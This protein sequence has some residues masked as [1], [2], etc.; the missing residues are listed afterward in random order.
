MPGLQGSEQLPCRALVDPSLPVYH[1]SFGETRDVTS[2]QCA[3]ARSI[4]GRLGQDRVQIPRASRGVCD[5]K[6]LLFFVSLFPP[7]P[8]APVSLSFLAASTRLTVGAK[9]AVKVT[10]TAQALVVR[11]PAHK[12]LQQASSPGFKSYSGGRFVPSPHVW[13][14]GLG[15]THW[16]LPS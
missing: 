15:S 13:P 11:V 14:L 1:G 10:L 8:V 4:R 3:S 5:G 6:V 12:A 9:N 16:Q 7:L 2:K